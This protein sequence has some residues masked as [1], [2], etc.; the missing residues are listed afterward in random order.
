[1][2][3]LSF[4]SKKEQL[5]STRVIQTALS[6]SNPATPSSI[7]PYGQETS[8]DSF[9]FPVL[10]EES[11]SV[12][13]VLII[14]TVIAAG[15][16][17]YGYDTGS[18]GGIVSM[19]KYIRV[20]G[21]YDPLTD[22][23]VIPPYR[24]GMIIGA[25]TLGALFGCL[26]GGK[27]AELWG[28][29]WGMAISSLLVCVAAIL[30]AILRTHWPAVFV[31]RFLTGLAIGALS[32]V[33]P[34]YLSEV[35]PTKLR[36]LLVSMFQFHIN[37]G[38]FFGELVCLCTSFWHQ[39]IGQYEIPIL[40][41][42]L[43]S[44]LM[45]A[46]CFFLLPES[47]RYLVSKNKID[48]ACEALGKVV[49]LPPD[50]RT[51][52]SEISIIKVSVDAERLEGEATWR[53]LF[54]VKDRIL[55][56]VVLS[57]VIMMFQQLS[58]V[59][60]FFYYG[61]SVFKAISNINIFVIPLILGGIN[62]M[63][64][65]AVLP[66]VGKYPRKHF[67]MAGSMFMFLSLCI[68]TCLGS[69]GLYSE[70]SVDH[71]RQTNFT[72]GAIMIVF[73]CIFIVS[74]AATWAPLSYV[75]VSEMFSQR[76]RSKA[77]PLATSASWAVNAIISFLAPIASTT[78]GYR[79]GFLFVA[80]MLLSFF[81][82]YFFTFETITLPL[83]T[84]QDMIL[85]GVSARKSAKWIKTNGV[86]STAQRQVE[87]DRNNNNNNNNSNGAKVEEMVTQNEIIEKDE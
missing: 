32:S 68:F 53:E 59:N 1:M 41:N 45:F 37:A 72:N 64:T 81:V 16:F 43:L 24:S 79:F 26:G 82:I 27:L 35:A 20:V 3:R 84:I 36:P 22:S 52:L 63:G 25:S 18:I 86:K 30:H 11:I 77:I 21:D 14:G 74:F 58:G 29:R 33:C 62:F 44:L 9:P 55:Y 40:F 2:S 75:V 31:C 6:T 34:M 78:I 83:E 56:R 42:C 15:G 50:S 60:Y 65:A 7:E 12:S 67:L 73:A 10:P 8:E 70:S 49:K 87:D 66:I 4:D 47:P 39:S 46:A 69:F 61:P 23:F 51:V 13:K 85:S 17:V 71:T 76:Y 57:I 48:E 19:P 54:H 5:D 38:V 28:R 80:C